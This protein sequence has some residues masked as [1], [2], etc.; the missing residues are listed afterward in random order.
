MMMTF[1]SSNIINLVVNA[2]VDALRGSSTGVFYPLSI[3]AR[4]MYPMREFR[5]RVTPDGKEVIVCINKWWKRY[6]HR[7]KKPNTVPPTDTEGIKTALNL[8]LP[9]AIKVNAVYDEGDYVQIY[10]EVDEDERNFEQG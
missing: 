4:P 3:L 1:S 5:P 9:A 2:L 7:S 8:R 10:L 6:K